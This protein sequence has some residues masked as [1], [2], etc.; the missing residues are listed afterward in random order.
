M[1]CPVQAEGAVAR[2]LAADAANPLRL[3][4]PIPGLVWA[5]R[6]HS[7]GRPEALQVGD[8]STF[9]HDGLLWLHFNLLD[10]QARHWLASSDL[11][12]P[13]QARELLLS[14]DNFQQLHN[15]DDCVY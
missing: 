7:D 3:S 9:G 15:E 6:I 12:L 5:F 4:T 14:K 2:A 11:H 8:P 1:R 10:A 13:F